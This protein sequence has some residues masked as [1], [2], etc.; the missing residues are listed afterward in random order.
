[1]KIYIKINMSGILFNNNYIEN[2][3]IKTENLNF[4]IKNIY[5]KKKHN[6]IIEEEKNENNPLNNLLNKLKDQNSIIKQNSKY[7]IDENSFENN[8]NQL[9]N[10]YNKNEN[11]IKGKNTDIKYNNNY[12]N[13]S[14]SGSF[15]FHLGNSGASKISDPFYKTPE[16]SNFFNCNSVDSQQNSIQN[17]SNIMSTNLET[18]ELLKN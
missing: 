12:I 18:E 13:C 11:Q 7:Y 8:N 2:E 9:N 4:K 17:I 15:S 16:N 14:F 10:K 1:M 3:E 5:L 6:P